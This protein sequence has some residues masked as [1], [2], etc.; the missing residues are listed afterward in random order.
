VSLQRVPGLTRLLGETFAK[1]GEE[2]K[3]R[4]AAIT[5]REMSLEAII[6]RTKGNYK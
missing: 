1:D 6:F 2:K 4:T 5:S 3:G